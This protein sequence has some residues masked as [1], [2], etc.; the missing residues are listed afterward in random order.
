MLAETSK[1]LGSH[2]NLTVKIFSALQCNHS[3]LT[4]P[5][6]MWQYDFMIYQ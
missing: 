2:D 1:D 3:A 6:D 5:Q 4:D